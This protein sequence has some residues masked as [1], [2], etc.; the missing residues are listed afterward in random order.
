MF[1]YLCIQVSVWLIHP[2]LYFSS[3][4]SNIFGCHLGGSAVVWKPGHLF[5][6]PTHRLKINLQAKWQSVLNLIRLKRLIVECR[7]LLLM[8]KEQILSSRSFWTW[9]MFL[10]LKYLLGTATALCLAITL[11]HPVVPRGATK[12]LQPPPQER[13]PF[14]HVGWGI[15]KWINKSN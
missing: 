13:C 11:I 12:H 15:I 8:W 14:I 5:L 1:R 6:L 9:G 7:D 10:Q 3:K 4:L 2:M